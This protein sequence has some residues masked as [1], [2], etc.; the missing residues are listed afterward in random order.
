MVFGISTSPNGHSMS[1][2]LAMSYFISTTFAKRVTSECHIRKN[3]D[4]KGQYFALAIG[5]CVISGASG[6]GAISG[7]A[8]NPAVALAL[9]LTSSLGTKKK[10]LEGWNA[11]TLRLFAGHQFF[12]LEGFQGSLVWTT[13]DFKGS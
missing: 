6:A 4:E 2:P 9:D 7:G 1:Q 13:I 10:R 8:F 11:T 5:F 3:K 12:I